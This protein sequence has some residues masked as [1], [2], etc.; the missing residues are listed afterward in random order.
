MSMCSL[1]QNI[2]RLN[3]KQLQTILE[4]VAAV[5]SNVV[6]RPVYEYILHDAK[7]QITHAEYYRS[8]ITWHKYFLTIVAY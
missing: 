8:Q 7:I 1:Y 4:L 6:I 5:S 3:P 2:R